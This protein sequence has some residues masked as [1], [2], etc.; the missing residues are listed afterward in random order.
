[1][2]LCCSVLINYLTQVHM[3]LLTLHHTTMIID[4]YHILLVQKV[5]ILCSIDS[6]IALYHAPSS[7]DSLLTALP[8][9]W[10]P[11]SPRSLLT[12]F[13]PH[14]APSSL[15]SLLAALPP[16]MQPVYLGK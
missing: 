8:P 10:I 3:Y 6:L 2:V 15:D 12:G 14:C 4:I 13:T 5:S 9:H 1:M 11:S 7:L 16:H